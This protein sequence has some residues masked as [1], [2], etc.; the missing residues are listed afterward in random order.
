M[1]KDLADSERAVPFVVLAWV[2]EAFKGFV[3]MLKHVSTA[4]SK[5]GQHEWSI[6]EL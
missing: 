5:K 6:F 1:Q 2:G 3:A 4:S